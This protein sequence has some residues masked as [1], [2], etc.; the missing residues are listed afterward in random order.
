M[1]WRKALSRSEAK[2]GC[3]LDALPSSFSRAGRQPA[4]V[5]D[6]GII[7][8]LPEATGIGT[9]SEVLAPSVEVDAFGRR[10]CA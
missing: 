4:L 1:P 8:L 3:V 7:D 9:Y 10:L 6:L 2:V 5:A